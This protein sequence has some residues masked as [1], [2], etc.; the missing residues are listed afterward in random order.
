MLILLLLTSGTL[1]AGEMDASNPTADFKNEIVSSI[2]EVEISSTIQQ[3]IEF[4]D[5]RDKYPFTPGQAADENK[6]KEAITCFNSKIEGRNEKDLAKLSD[7]LGLQKFGLVSSKSQKDLTEYLSNNLYKSLTGVDPTTKDLNALVEQMKFGKMK[8]VDQKVFIDLYKTQIIKNSLYEVSRFCFENLRIN[9]PTRS[10]NSFIEHWGNDLAKID[11]SKDINNPPLTDIG[12]KGFGS[13]PDT[14]SKEAI[15][16][17]MLE[18]IGTNQADKVAAMSDFFLSCGAKIVPLCNVFREN[19]KSK[20]DPD[21]KT[22]ANAC[23]TEAKLQASRK[24]IADIGLIQKQFDGEDFSSKMLIAISNYNS[25]NST[26]PSI[27]ELTNYSSADILTGG[28]NENKQ[29]QDLQDECIKDPR[30]KECEDFL[31][32]GDTAEKAQHKLDLEMRFKKEVELKRISQ[33]KG[34]EKDLKTY[35]EENGYI[36]LLKKIENKEQVDLEKEIAAIYDAKRI[37]TLDQMKAKIGSRQIS[38]DDSKDA[39]MKANNI[40]ENAQLSKEE[41]VRMAQVVLFNNIITGSLTLKKKDTGELVGRNVNVLKKE[42]AGLEKAKIDPKLFDNIKVE[43][44]KSNP[45]G[46]FDDAARILDSI[47]SSTESKDDSKS[48]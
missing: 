23:L 39:N 45:T 46:S 28:L 32:V 10:Q 3:S 22:G 26:T 42:L 6:I 27:D 34:N 47:L 20:K 21:D 40:K 41:R 31:N 48:K 4:K 5:C 33:L 1:L 15:Y 29:Q 14:G 43:D 30:K 36:D 24:A 8:M 38:E 13:F 17:T 12:S 37:A 19:L 7:A 44:G 9:D 11:G 16:K 18:G 25:S 2:K 35:L